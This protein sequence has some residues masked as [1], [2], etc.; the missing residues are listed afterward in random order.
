MSSDMLHT[1]HPVL[2]FHKEGQEAGGDWVRRVCFQA[3]SKQS[4]EELPNRYSQSPGQM[5]GALYGPG[6]ARPARG[7]EGGGRRS[8]DHNIS[9]LRGPG[10]Q[11]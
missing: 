2:M 7:R 10:R 4:R 3:A 1:N 6:E 5:E 9:N 8:C 11:P